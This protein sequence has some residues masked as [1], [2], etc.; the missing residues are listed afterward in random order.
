MIHPIDAAAAVP[1][2]LLT[3]RKRTFHGGWGD[4]GLLALND[5]ATL[6]PEEIRAIDI[7]WGPARAC[8]SLVV[9]DGTFTSPAASLPAQSR[10]GFVRRIA[11]ATGPRAWCVWMAAWNDHDWKTRTAL[12][13]RT[14]DAGI[15]SVLLMNPYYGQRSPAAKGEQP[16]ATV[17]D[18]G[19]MGRA[20]VI[21]GAGVL[22]TLRREGL[23]VGV[24]GYSM[25][26]NIGAMVSASVPFRVA[27]AALAVSHSPAPVFLSG[28]PGEAVDWAALGG[29]TES[30]GRLASILGSASVLRMP[31]P[32][33]ADIAVLVGSR[34]DGFVPAA[35]TEALHHHWPGSEL[36]WLRGGHASMLWFTK[37]ELVDAVVRSFDRLRARPASG[38][39]Q[40]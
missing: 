25:G 19:A 7:D 4:E 39:L 21:E 38:P 17:A 29:R 2:R 16:I 8:D 18:F 14:A 27:T 32:P 28:P 6:R 26:G 20:A 40:P 12:A 36:R 11:P 31:A 37:D 1:L 23:P 33:H 9:T 35:A 30:V 5:A 34:R 3:G 10:A 15:G 13:A 22:M 24:S